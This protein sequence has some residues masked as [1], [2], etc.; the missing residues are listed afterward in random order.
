MNWTA[1]D[2]NSVP[3]IDDWSLADDG[4]SNTQYI[5][6]KAN[7]YQPKY[8]LAMRKYSCYGNRYNYLINMYKPYTRIKR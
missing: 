1:N 2:V 4:G 7:L 6:I 8:L 3:Y 5:L